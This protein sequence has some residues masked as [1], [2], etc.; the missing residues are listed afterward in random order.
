MRDPLPQ[1]EAEWQ[2]VLSPEK[3]EILRGHGTEPPFNNEYWDN[4][5]AGAYA[6]A[7][8]GSLL[9]TSDTKFD[10][11]TGWPSFFQPVSAE[12]IA[13]TGDTS[14]G[15]SRDEVICARC[16]SHLGHVFSD[17]PEPTGLRYCMNSGA[18][19]FTPDH[20]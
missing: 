14:H 4:H 16:E 19:A 6:C 20:V 5:E 1:T 3:Y 11:G 8:C 18:L 17:G 9:F 13:V 7:A 12:A 2:A 10:S 15:M